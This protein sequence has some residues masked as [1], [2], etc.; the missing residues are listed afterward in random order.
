M[1]IIIIIII[2]IIK[3]VIIKIIIMIAIKI[4]IGLCCK[5]LKK[6]PSQGLIQQNN[7]GSGNHTNLYFS[8]NNGTF[9]L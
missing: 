1:I 3:I 5:P 9:G 8:F 7:L 2:I 4:I 6:Y